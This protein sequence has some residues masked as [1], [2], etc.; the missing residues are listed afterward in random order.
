MATEINIIYKDL[1]DWVERPRTAAEK[2]KDPGA[3]KKSKKN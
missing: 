2:E 3:E 1:D